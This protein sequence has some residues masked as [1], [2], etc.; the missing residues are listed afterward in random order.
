MR[1]TAIALAAST[2][3]LMTSVAGVTAAEGDDPLP[4]WNDGAIKDRIIAF[5]DAVTTPDSPDF[6]PVAERIAAFDID[7]TL[8]AERPF[9]ND[10]LFAADRVKALAA[11]NPEWADQ[12]P[13]APIVAGDYDV[14]NHIAAVDFIRL[15]NAAYGDATDP[16]WEKV[17]EDWFTTT[18]NETLGRTIATTTYQPMMELLDYLRANEFT[19]Y[20]VTAA[21]EQFIRSVSDEIF[22]IP[23]EQVIGN[24]MER[25]VTTNE[26]GSL[27]VTRV[28]VTAIANERENKV[29][30]IFSA[31][32]RKPILVAGNSD[33]DYWMM[34]WATSDDD[35]GLSILVV[36]D[37]ADREFD[38][39]RLPTLGGAALES[40][41]EWLGVSMKD[42]WSTVFA[43]E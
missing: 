1:R 22:N 24:E 6:V 3:L 18:T 40:D 38:Y 7:G 2:V 33:G 15:M 41:P 31:T 35:P 29:L 25:V 20:L 39:Q 14:V 42:A 34:K 12:L 17:V 30:Q 19:P 11:D 10:A 5:V 37:D 27:T 16:E 43:Q 8:W 4:S 13:F 21:E 36:H 9:Y 28:P 32:G 26:D 23:R